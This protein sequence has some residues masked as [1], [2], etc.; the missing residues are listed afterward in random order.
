MTMAPSEVVDS[1]DSSMAIEPPA[2]YI[3]SEELPGAVIRTTK[4]VT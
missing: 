1:C 2:G 3:E 4:A